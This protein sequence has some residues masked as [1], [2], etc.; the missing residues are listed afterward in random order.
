MKNNRVA[1]ESNIE[2]LRVLSM[3]GVIVLHYNNPIFGG[4]LMYAVPGSVNFYIWLCFKIVLKIYKLLREV[5][6][7]SLN[8]PL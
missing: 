4:G 7:T 2:L 3:M 8:S 1:R 5:I 6:L